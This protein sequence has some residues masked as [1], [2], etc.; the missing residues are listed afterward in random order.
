MCDWCAHKDIRSKI[1]IDS[2]K[3]R[4]K[5]HP[6]VIIF[7]KL[8][9]RYLLTKNAKNVSEIWFNS[10]KEKA[11]N[12]IYTP[13]NMCPILLSSTLQSHNSL[14]KQSNCPTNEDWQKSAKIYI[15]NLMKTEI[16]GHINNNNN[17]KI[18]FKNIYYFIPLNS[19]YIQIG[20]A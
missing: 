20:D 11:K 12:R 7:T 1:K 2:L 14:K 15:F 8:S 6:S 9:I 19:F 13:K 4:L 18:D 10:N 3:K 17:R 16:V 5:F